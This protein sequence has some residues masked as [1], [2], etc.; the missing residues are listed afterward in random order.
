MRKRN[1]ALA[2][3]IEAELDDL[4]LRHTYLSIVV[5][6]IV[7]ARFGIDIREVA[8]N[9]PLD[10]IS[11]QTFRDRTGIQGIIEPDFFS[12]P[13]ETNGGEAIRDIARRVARFDWL[14]APADIGATLYESVIPADER[15]K[16]GEY[17]T[18]A[19]L[20]KAIVAETVHN[21]LK[22]RVLDPSCGS[23]T[24]IVEA[25]QHF[26]SA[27]ARSDLAPAD[28]LK[29]LTE[30]V[31]GI[32]IHP[33][34][35]QLARTAWLLAAKPAIDAVVASGG[36]APVSVP[37][38]LGDSLLL[39][40]RGL[41]VGDMISDTE[42]RIPIDEGSTEELIFPRS[43]VDRA[44]AFDLLMTNTARAI[45]R[46]ENPLPLID[47]HGVLPHERAVVETALKLMQRLH[48]EGR[49]HIWAYYTRNLVRPLVLMR[50]PKR[51][52]ADA[53]LGQGLGVDVIVGNPPWIN[54]NKTDG[55]LR[56]ELVRLSQREYGIW[57][58]GHYATQQDVA[59]LFYARCIDL[60]LK[61]GGVI[62]MVMPHSALLTGQHAKWRTGEWKSTSGGKGFTRILAVHF[63][64]KAA[65]DL[66]RLEPNSFFPVP[67]CVVFA[68]RAGMDTKGS[69]LTGSVERWSGK[70]GAPNPE[71]VPVALG[72]A[73]EGSPY[74][75][76]TANGATIFPRRLFLVDEVVSTV[77]LEAEPLV[78]V[79]PRMGSQ[80]KMPWKDLNLNAITGNPIE[81]EYL[82]DVHL[83]E[84]LGPYALLPAL[85]AL[86]PLCRE[87][88]G[89]LT[90]PLG[91]T[92]GLDAAK[93]RHRMGG[94][95]RAISSLWEGNRGTASKLSLLEQ[96]DYYGKLSA[97][98]EWQAD[99]GNTPVRVIYS[100][101]GRPTAALLADDT[102][103][104]D[105][106]LFTTFCRDTAEANYLLAIINSDALYAR[107]APLMP[108]GQFGA[109]HVQKHLWKLPIPTFDAG[110]ALHAEIA[111]AGEAAAKGAAAVYDKL[112]ER[113]ADTPEKLTV[114]LVRRSL[115][116]WLAESG[117]GR[118]VES[119]VSRLLRG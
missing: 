93:L 5:A 111:G 38:Y 80:D 96:L 7:Q 54:Y 91:D 74:S 42:A 101:S 87:P 32:D 70:A 44:S 75:R 53:D 16:L 100:G 1:N 83:G 71:R 41:R 89:R 22:Q 33:V 20:A 24:F 3:E 21:P 82:V 35:V 119:A 104:V 11:G 114:T 18:P 108:K 14:H 63:S 56:D 26:L 55:L 25:V 15:R 23:G 118:A 31:T 4:F 106:T 40:F 62:G 64:W 88:S 52:I 6:L 107:V 99:K 94:R 58:G 113:Y 92:G 78:T 60:Y 79:Q 109:R 69:P 29:R 47:S 28:V 105:Y 77:V 39:R 81:Q 2:Q 68:K 36:S 61:D 65:W 10:L 98:L 43:L 37:V 34:A 27:A 95:W 45:E 116:E 90:L 30:A 9:N 86:L 59:S 112:R 12:W 66:E 49:N 8:E 85:K 115:R 19:W 102:A 73:N 72:T 50:K 76:T 13:A 84:T 48:G 67:A 57:A 103:F 51:N 117:E 46:G 110:N 97:Q 17:Y